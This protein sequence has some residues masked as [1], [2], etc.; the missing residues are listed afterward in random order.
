MKKTLVFVGV[1]LILIG[2][3]LF[4]VDSGSPGGAPKPVFKTA[5]VL[6]GDLSVKISATGIVEPNFKVEVKSKASG[7][8]LSFPFEEGDRVKKGTLLLQLDKSDEQ[9]NV[10]KART[11]LSSSAAKHKKAKTSLLLQK[12]KYDTDMK[13]TQSEIE[14]AIANLKEAEDKLKR[15]SE[16][17][18][19]KFVSQES[20]DAARTLFKVNQENLVQAQTRFQT[21]KDSIHDITMKENEIELVL[22]EVKRSEISLDEVAERLDETEI[23]APINGVIIEKFIEEGQIIASGISNV[24]GGTAIATIADMSLL[25]IIADIDETDIGAVKVGHA[26]RITADAFPDEVFEGKV[27]R[28]APQGLIENSITIFKV[29]IEVQGAGRNLLKPMMSANIDIVTHLV[30][31]TVYASRAGLRKDDEG[32]FAVVLKNDQPEKVRVKIGIRNPIHAQ[33]VSGLNP[34]EE[35]ILGDW[36]KVIEESKEKKSSSLKKILWMIRSK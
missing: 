10:A 26:V 34:D 33:V 6:R 11:E 15:Q 29:K 36:E 13:S 31:D 9:R 19:K 16:L 4:P 21:A 3:Y 12:T 18:E 20:L 25:F 1:A 27:T 32:E 7:E 2:L 24:S 17:F 5:K 22:S 14:T 28:I 8:V 30:K 23:F 35:V